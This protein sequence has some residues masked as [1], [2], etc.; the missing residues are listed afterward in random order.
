MA[1]KPVRELTKKE[2]DKCKSDLLDQKQT[3]LNSARL[4]LMDLNTSPDDRPD[5]ADLAQSDVSLSMHTRLGNRENLYL[6]KV[7]QALERISDGNYGECVSCSEPI[8]F[9]RLSVRPTA[10]LC[11]SCKEEE[12]KKENLSV[13]G[14]R[15]KSVGRGMSTNS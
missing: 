6:K 3:I 14:S 13:H 11:I 12:E 10:E 2:V 7:L 5:E 9:A 1:K 8:G 4:K 15:H